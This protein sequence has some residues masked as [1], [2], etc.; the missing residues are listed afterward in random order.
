[1]KLYR[2]GP[3]ERLVFID[4]LRL[5]SDNDNDSK[6]ILAVTLVDKFMTVHPEHYLLFYKLNFP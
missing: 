3:K 4:S 1:M 5:V 2:T 6:N